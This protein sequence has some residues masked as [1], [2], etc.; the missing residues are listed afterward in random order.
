MLLCGMP[1]LLLRRVR[2]ARGS[3]GNLVPAG[4]GAADRFAVI[5]CE[6]LAAT[7]YLCSS[8][9]RSSACLTQR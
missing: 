7:G 4:A 9:P 2:Y 1:W 5:G 6:S 3:T 8:F